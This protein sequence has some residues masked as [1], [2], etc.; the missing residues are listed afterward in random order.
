MHGSA[1]VLCKGQ[2]EKV[3]L[4][5]SFIVHKNLKTGAEV[6]RD[7]AAA[8][9]EAGLRE[10]L[11]LIQDKEIG[12]LSSLQELSAVGHRV[13]HGGDAFSDSARITDEIEAKI[14][15]CIELAPMHNPSNLMGIRVVKQMLPSVPQVAVFD[16]AFHQTMPAHAFLY[17]IPYKYYE[18]HKVRKYGFHGTSHQYVSG[19][20]AEI[21]GRELHSLKLISCHLGNGA[22]LTA[23]LHGQ[24]V[25]TTMGFTPLE[26][27]VMGTRS[28]DIDPGAVAFIAEREGLDHAGVLDLLNK[29]SGTKGISGV[30]PDMRDLEQ[31]A[32]SGNARARLAREIFSYRVVRYIGAYAAAMNGVDAIIFTGGIGEHD[33]NIREDICKNLSYLGAHINS[34]VNKQLR[35]KAGT[36]SRPES[37]VSL[38]VIPTD[39]E[40]MIARETERLAAE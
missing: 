19:Q 12:S 35:G 31:A 2:A 8:S 5:D 30:S 17:G 16:T 29:Q 15:E 21:L 32:E 7:K 22:S 10:V 18:E 9:H 3:G 40:L 1:E 14:E 13:V 25:D 24:S 23:V 4:A 26:G 37:L 11:S 20:A 6:R 27:L 39:E 36:I 34:S 28:G 38:L 33:V